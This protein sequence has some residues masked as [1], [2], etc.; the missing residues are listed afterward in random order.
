MCV[1]FNHRFSEQIAL[2][3]LLLLG[4]KP[5][6]CAVHPCTHGSVPPCCPFLHRGPLRG[7]QPH[8]ALG[9]QELR[10]D[11]SCF[12]CS[13]WPA[14]RCRLWEDGPAVPTEDAQGPMEAQSGGK[15][16]LQSLGCVGDLIHPSNL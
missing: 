2:F 3:S 9:P 5:L 10:S 1:V 13:T 16:S 4:G 12:H 15:L 7:A 8:Q 6:G 11:L 14:V